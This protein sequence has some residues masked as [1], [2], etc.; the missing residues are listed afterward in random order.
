MVYDGKV[1]I[2]N[3]NS[4]VNLGKGREVIAGR[5]AEGKGLQYVAAR[6]S[7]RVEQR[8][9]QYLSQAS[10]YSAQPMYANRASM[11]RVGGMARVGIGIRGLTL[12]PSYRA[13]GS[14]TARL[15]GGFTH[16]GTADTRRSVTSDIGADMAT[17]AGRLSRGHSPE[18]GER[19]T[20]PWL[21]QRVPR[22]CGTGTA[23][24]IWWIPRRIP[25]S[26]GG[27][28]RRFHGG[29]FQAGRRFH[30]GGGRH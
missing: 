4:H 21:L 10:I 19:G 6:R 11:V 29:G 9:A 30:G 14:S 22:P 12:I 3:G 1:K 25:W 5:E 18:L 23:F 26:H 28:R 16:H 20:E 24:G 8:R 7:I 15:A 2:E 17:T 13:M 27:F